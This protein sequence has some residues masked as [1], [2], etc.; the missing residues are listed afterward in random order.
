[1]K[2][3]TGAYESVRGAIQHATRSGREAAAFARLSTVFADEQAWA[4]ARAGYDV[5]GCIP[6]D[7][8]LGGVQ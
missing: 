2:P 1:V 4:L 6:V 8:L 5:I 7:R 3:S